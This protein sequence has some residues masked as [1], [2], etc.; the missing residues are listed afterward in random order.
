M[1]KIKTIFRIEHDPYMDID[2]FIAIFPESKA[3]SRGD[4][5]CLPFWFDGQWHFE[6]HGEICRWYYWKTKHIKNKELLQN[7][8]EVVEAFYNDMPDEKVE[9]IIRQKWM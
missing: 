7:L 3:N 5:N 1:K 6:S 9:L 2:K 8:K 4:V